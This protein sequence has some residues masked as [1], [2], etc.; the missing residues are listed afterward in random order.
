[1][2]Y[3]IAV[4]I[5]DDSLL[6]RSA[7]KE[8]LK[9]MGFNIIADVENVQDL[10]DALTATKKSPDVCLVDIKLTVFD[11]HE[12]L[13]KIRSRYPTVKVLGMTMLDN[14]ISRRKIIEAGADGCIVKT[15]PT[16]DLENQILELFK[17]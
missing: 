6:F 2:T 16:E 8:V 12:T 5:I 13:K 10:F 15:D 9:I 7:L 4:A 14:E 1:M 3:N 11:L 17:Q